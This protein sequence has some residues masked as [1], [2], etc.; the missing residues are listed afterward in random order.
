MHNAFKVVVRLV[1][2]EVRLWIFVLN[3]MMN[4]SGESTFLRQ[5]VLMTQPKPYARLVTFS[6]ATQGSPCFLQNLYKSNLLLIIN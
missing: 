6:K 4:S 5:L 1:F 3:A 2:G